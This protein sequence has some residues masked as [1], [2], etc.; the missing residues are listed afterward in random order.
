MQREQ[1]P[2]RGAILYREVSEQL[3]P[4][5]LHCRQCS[6]FSLGRPFSGRRVYLH[7]DMELDELLLRPDVGD[8][9]G[10]GSLFLLSPFPPLLIL[11][12]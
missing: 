9:V 11:E 8:I 10:S 3:R 12:I 1:G 7:S 5:R 4:A 2:P 6:G